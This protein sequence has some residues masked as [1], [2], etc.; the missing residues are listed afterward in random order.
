[1]L[2]FCAW[3]HILDALYIQYMHHCSKYFNVSSMCFVGCTAVDCKSWAS[4]LETCCH[5]NLALFEIGQV[6]TKIKNIY[7][8]GQKETFFYLNT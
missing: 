2:P 4:Q 1:M 8:M 6:Q 5:G 3:D 7:Y